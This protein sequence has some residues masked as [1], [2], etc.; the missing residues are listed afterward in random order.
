MIGGMEN[1]KG[2]I[3]H[4]SVNISLESNL[5]WS[6][7]QCLLSK[8]CLINFPFEESNHEK[9]SMTPVWLK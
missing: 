4:L 2:Y 8:I 5:F 6:G 3:N 7:I 9:T 1:L